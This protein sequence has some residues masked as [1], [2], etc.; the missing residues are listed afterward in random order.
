M[1]KRTL[2]IS[3]LAVTFIAVC[4]FGFYVTKER[5][6]E[7]V[8]KEFSYDLLDKEDYEIVNKEVVEN[9]ATYNIATDL[10]LNIDEAEFLANKLYAEELGNDIDYITMNVFPNKQMATEYNGEL[11]EVAQQIQVSKKDN[12]LSV[13]L[14]NINVVTGGGSTTPTNYTINSVVPAGDVTKVEVSIPGNLDTINALSQMKI[15][16]QSIRDLNPDKNINEIY[17]N[18]VFNDQEKL[19]YDYYS[20]Y[21]NIILYCQEA[22]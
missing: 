8:I 4:G 21:D 6:V 2:L 9:N 20:K 19:S 12:K 1:K 13:K 14:N 3:F 15:I 5:K 17:I 18:A 16:A 11:E 22:E 10:K 7:V